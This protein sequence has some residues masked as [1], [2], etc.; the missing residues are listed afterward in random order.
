MLPITNHRGFHIPHSLATAAAIVALVT[1]LSWDASERSRA[2]LDSAGATHDQVTTASQDGDEAADEPV[3][4]A[5]AGRTDHT[6]GALSGLLP[7]V[8]PSIS[9]I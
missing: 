5:R 4:T 7:L 3:R 1:A 2:E 9:G 8:L 6:P